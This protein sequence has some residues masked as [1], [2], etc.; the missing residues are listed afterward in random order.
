M[1]WVSA[2]DD[3]GGAFALREEVFC[4]EQGVAPEDE[5]DGR[6][7]E[8]DHLL[9]LD[10][11]GRVAG[12]LR[13]LAGGDVAKIGRVAV[14]ADSRRQGIALSMLERA[15]ERARAEGFVRARLAAQTNAVEVYRRAGFAVESDAF[16]QAG[17]EHVWMGLE[18]V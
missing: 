7:D 4:R 6:D 8:A 5:L 2:E 16:T 14:R 18:L 17:I 11:D 1:R 9:A 13:V 15:I 3:L 10:E 12:T